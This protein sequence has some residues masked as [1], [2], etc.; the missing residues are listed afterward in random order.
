MGLLSFFSRKN[1]KVSNTDALSLALQ[2]ALEAMDVGSCEAFYSCLLQSKLLVRTEMSNGNLTFPTF[3]DGTVPIFSSLSRLL[4]DTSIDGLPSYAEV[5][6]TELFAINPGINYHLNPF[7][8]YKKVLSAVE[9]AYVTTPPANFTQQINVPRGTTILTGI[10]AE[11]PE[12]MLSF[13]RTHFGM[14]PC[15]AKAYLNLVILQGADEVPHYLVSVLLDQEL[16]DFSQLIP[17][18][19]TRLSG[20]GNYVDFRSIV[21]GDVDEENSMLFYKRPPK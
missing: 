3:S 17:Q 8:E 20:D 2:K 18:D 9:I 5:V 11:V 14:F 10:P 19:M 6:A 7:S 12:T 21:P 4:D 13:L 15:V 16:Q 1:K